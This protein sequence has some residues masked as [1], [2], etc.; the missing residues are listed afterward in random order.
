MFLLRLVFV[1]QKEEKQRK[2]EKEC[3][4]SVGTFPQWLQW[5]GLSKVKAGPWNS[6]QVSHVGA[7]TRVSGPPAAAFQGALTGSCLR[8][9]A[10]GTQTSTAMGCWQGLLSA[11][12]HSTGLE[13][14]FFAECQ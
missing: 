3:L 8:I 10:A 5:P 4:P 9:G 11:L 7:G 2:I 14:L 6:T 13:K 1:F 12:H